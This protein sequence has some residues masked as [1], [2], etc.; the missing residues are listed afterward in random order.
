MD[1]FYDYPPITTRV[2]LTTVDDGESNPHFFD[3]VDV[4]SEDLKRL[5]PGSPSDLA[6]NITPEPMHPAFPPAG[7]TCWVAAHDSKV[8]QETPMIEPWCII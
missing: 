4:G 6:V 8:R 5:P 7:L 2:S 3:C 1:F